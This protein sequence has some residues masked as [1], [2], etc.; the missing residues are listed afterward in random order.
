[1]ISSAADP[2]DPIPNSVVKRGSPNDTWTQFGPGKVGHRRDFFLLNFFVSMIQPVILAAGKGTRMK[3]DLPKVLHELLGKTF[4]QRVID[5]VE[6]ADFPKPIIVLGDNE[7]VIKSA[8]GPDYRYVRQDVPRGTAHAL[9]SCEKLLKDFK[10]SILVLYGDHPLTS[11]ESLKRIADHHE[12]NNL[13]L[14]FFTAV[15]PDFEGPH[16]PFAHYGRIIRDDGQIRIVEKKEAT[17]EQLAIKEVNLGM[18]CFR[19]PWIWEALKKATPHNA[20]G[21]YYLTDMIKIAQDFGKKVGTIS[22][23]PTEAMGINTQEDLEIAE[24]IL[25]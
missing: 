1:M 23:P 8:I 17:P 13:D 24:E 3:S 11:S 12:Q 4:L 15:L 21:E 25:K 9:Q 22:L 16:A 2:P 6:E 20:S 14:T 5:A 7:E 19:S 18:Y 10:G